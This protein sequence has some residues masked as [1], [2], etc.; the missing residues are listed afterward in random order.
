MFAD[1]EPASADDFTCK[2]T[3]AP[4]PYGAQGLFFY[5]V[6]DL[7]NNKVNSTQKSVDKSLRTLFH[8]LFTPGGSQWERLWVTVGELSINFGASRF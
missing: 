5:L 4:E 6:I 2:Y 8:L 1:Q 7:N 3:G